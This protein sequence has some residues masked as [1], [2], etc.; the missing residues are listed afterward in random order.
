MLRHS[1]GF[2][3]GFLLGQRGLEPELP[4]FSKPQFLHLWNGDG[5]TFP[6]FTP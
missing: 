4:D 3:P 2:V 5:G 1:P 6:S